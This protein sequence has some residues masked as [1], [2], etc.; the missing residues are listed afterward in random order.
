MKVSRIDRK[1]LTFKEEL[2]DS[3]VN[4][5]FA[6]ITN[7]SVDQNLLKNVYAEWKDFFDYHGKLEYKAIAGNASG[8][9]PMKSENAKGNNVKDLK[10]FFHLF[11]PFR[12][13]PQGMTYSTSVL[14]IDLNSLG[15]DL[16]VQLDRE[17]QVRNKEYLCLSEMAEQSPNTLLRIL[18]Y[19][20]I[21]LQGSSDGA[22]R[23][24]A[25]ED[26]NL[27]TLLPA[28]TYP[29]LQVKDKEGNWHF[30]DLIS[31]EGDIICNVGD[32]LQEATNGKLKST[33]HRVVNPTGHGA[34]VSRYSMP[35]FM[36]ACPEV[37]LSNRYTAG[38]YLKQRLKE[39]GLK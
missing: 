11:Y 1:S 33:T 24:A 27:I 22:V 10:E 23:A 9:F 30:V 2:Y 38:E 17:Y 6:I 28:A 26:I 15:K 34:T 29:G 18:H 13:I 36:H 19:P 4:T 37:R 25:H 14:A 8:F 16:L 7:H 12:Q 21:G 32:M 3:F 31:E 20:P 35:L 39:I 5:G